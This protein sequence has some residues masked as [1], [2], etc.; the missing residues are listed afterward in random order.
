[1]VFNLPKSAALML[2]AVLLT[3]AGHVTV[4]S[5]AASAKPANSTE[6]KTTQSA[7]SASLMAQLKLTDK[8]KNEIRA[9]RSSRTKQINQVLTPEQKTKFEQARKSGKTLSEALK[10]LNLKPEQ[11]SKI[12]AIAKSS[13]ADIKSKLN[14]QQVKQLEAY[15]KQHQSGATASVE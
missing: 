6:V 2:A 11:K 3:L 4:F 14:P 12:L 15:I 1:M 8:Q 9:I 13:A 5:D 10:E 7:S